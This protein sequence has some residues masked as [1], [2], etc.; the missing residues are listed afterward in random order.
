MRI[1][2]IYLFGI[3]ATQI[4]LEPLLAEDLLELAALANSGSLRFNTF[5]P[6]MRILQ[7]FIYM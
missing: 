1:S 3:S 7:P 2:F 5:V 4:Y 6:N